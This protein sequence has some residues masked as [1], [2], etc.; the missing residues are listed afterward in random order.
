MLTDMHIRFF[1]HDL[2]EMDEPEVVEI[3]LAKFEAILAE[4]D[5]EIN[6]SRHTILAN[7]VRQVCLTIRDF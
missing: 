1:H 4:G 3:D 2:D 6:Y 7:G 5:Y